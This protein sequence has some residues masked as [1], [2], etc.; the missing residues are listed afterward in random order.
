MSYKSSSFRVNQYAL[1]TAG[2]GAGECRGGVIRD[3]DYHILAD[4]AHLT[5]TFGRHK[6]LPWG[7]EGGKPG[8][9]NEVR[10]ISAHGE[11]E[12]VVLAFIGHK[13]QDI[14]IQE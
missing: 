4:E 2:G 1:N 9:R 10:I 7:M 11:P 14:H 12:Q 5:A 6:F 13:K 8:T 3:Y